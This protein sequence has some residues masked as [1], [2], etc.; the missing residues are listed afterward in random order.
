MHQKLSK[1]NS[2]GIY[3]KMRFSYLRMTAAT[4]TNEKQNLY[5]PK[6]FPKCTEKLF[7]KNTLQSYLAVTNY[8]KNK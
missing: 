2:L 3:S 1:C 8:L 7:D 6:M 4:K 5:C